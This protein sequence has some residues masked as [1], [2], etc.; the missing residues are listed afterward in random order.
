MRSLFA[1]SLTA[2]VALTVGAAPAQARRA[3]AIDVPS[4]AVLTVTGHGFGHGHGMSQYGA[5]GA[6]RQGLTA[7]QI[8]AF[9]YPGTDAGTRGGRISVGLS[10]T[11]R[12]DLVVRPRSGL[13][14]RDVA[15]GETTE[16]PADGVSR[17]RVRVRDDGARVARLPAGAPAKGGWEPVVDLA[18]SGELD[19]RNRPVSMVTPSG[20]RAYRG[21]LRLVATGSAPVVV[22]RLR[23]E[24][25]L[26][27]VV[28]REMPASWSPAAVQAQ[29]IA[30]RT[31]AAYERA[32][33]V[34]PDY[35]VC[36]TTSCQV[37]GGVGSENP[38]SDDAVAA[39]ARQVVLADGAAAF[40][41]FG[42]SSGGYTSAGSVPYLVAQADPY[43]GWSGNGYHDWT[44]Q[45]TDDRIESQWPA[46][47]DLERIVVLDTEG[48]RRV[49]S[50]RLVGS[51]ATV[52]LTGD[53]ARSGLGLPS[54]WFRFSVR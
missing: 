19:A 3:A 31:Y 35:Q 10:G 15:T 20:D 48:G 14:V 50:L 22:N 24:D 38:L 6:A 7:Q 23:L 16:L 39:T 45:V 18:G 34:S 44:R 41:Q 26:R 13:R 33:P 21:R 25:Y 51:D 5:E 17:Y 11:G 27:G 43:D 40:T 12:R 49:R 32:H 1:V 30:A 54:T 2:L 52:T 53:A 4:D 8:V 36:D 29:A 28:P 47:G 9:Y 37:Y 46:L 42:S